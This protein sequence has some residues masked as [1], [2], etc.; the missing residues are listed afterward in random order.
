MKICP[1][2]GEQRPDEHRM[3]SFCGAQLSE[4]DYEDQ[5][6]RVQQCPS[7][8]VVEQPTPV[9][10]QPAPAYEQPAPAYEQPAPA[11]EQPA[12]A[13]EQPAP[14]YEQH[15]PAYAPAPE[16]PASSY[17][18]PAPAYQQPVQPVSPVTYAQQPT[19]GTPNAPAPDT[20]KDG[21]GKKKL[22]IILGVVGGFVLIVAILLVLIFTHVICLFHEYEPATCEDPETCEYCGKERGEPEEHKWLDATC[23]APK[24]CEECGEED[25]SP[26]GHDWLDATCT[27]P[28]TC[29]T[30]SETEGEPLGHLKT[31][32]VTTKEPT[33]MEK[34]RQKKVCKQCKTELETDDVD[35]KDAQVNGESF[36]FKDEEFIAWMNDISTAEIE[37]EDL[38]MDGLSDTATSYY[39]ILPD[40]IAGIIVFNHDDDGYIS[41]IMVYAEDHEYA[42]LFAIYIGS[43]IDPAFSSDDALVKYS[44]GRP[45]TGGG[46]T[47]TEVELEEDFM[48]GLLAPKDA[49]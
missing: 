46:M 1:R 40:D 5:T 13:Y 7:T 41:A 24:T 35:V 8:P 4:L 18:Q 9:F 49:F 10:E 44:N 42:T 37:G 38:K 30:C 25:G 3:C 45:Y 39:V 21:S 22:G 36:N 15:T 31:E 27:E 32:W 26:A 14:A 2:C 23:I 17:Q 34:G 48:V 6:V 20:Q 29:Q 12:P 47:V 19:P 43:K 33:L 16:Q 28:K 11:Y